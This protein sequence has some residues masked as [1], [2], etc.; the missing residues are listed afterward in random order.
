MHTRHGGHRYEIDNQTS[1]LGFHFTECGLEQ[2]ELQIIDCV[3]VGRDMALIQ[4]EGVW[5][6]RL[7]TFQVHG[8]INIRNELR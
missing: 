7:A 5:Q 8:N 1:Q 2:L 4:L 6:T 3:K